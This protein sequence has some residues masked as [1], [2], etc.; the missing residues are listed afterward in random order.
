MTS[1]TPRIPL[2]LPSTSLSISHAPPTIY[3][4]PQ[5]HKPN[6]SDHLQM[7]YK[8]LSKYLNCILV[9]LLA[10]FPSHIHNTNHVL[11]LFNSFSFP[12]GLSQLLFTLVIKSLYTVIPHNEGLFAL[13]HFLDL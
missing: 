1:F 3:F 9:P 12:P 13:K 11:C 4:F 10:S 5:I 7:S 6:N 8:N 2:L